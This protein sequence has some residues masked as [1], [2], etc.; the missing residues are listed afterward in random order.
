MGGLGF[1]LFWVL[2]VFLEFLYPWPLVFLFGEI[3]ILLQRLVSFG[4]RHRR[5]G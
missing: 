4:F 5:L 3:L 2:L 1:L